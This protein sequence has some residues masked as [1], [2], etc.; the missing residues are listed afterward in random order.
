MILFY[1][2]LSK[3]ENLIFLRRKALMIPDYK[4]AFNEAVKLARLLNKEVGLLAIKNHEGYGYAVRHLPR[5][6]NRCGNELR[7]QIVKPDDPFMI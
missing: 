4:T 2:D 3:F 1:K 5:P 6:E 7:A